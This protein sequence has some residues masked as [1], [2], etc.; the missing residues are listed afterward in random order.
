MANPSSDW[1]V[2]SNHVDPLVRDAISGFGFLDRFDPFPS[3]DHL[4]SD[5]GIDAAGSDGEAVFIAQHLWDRLGGNKPQLA[6]FG[7][8]GGDDACSCCR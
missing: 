8:V 1:N 7:H 3:K 6:G 4:R 5:V 2:K